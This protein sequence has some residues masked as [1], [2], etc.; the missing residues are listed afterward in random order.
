MYG[1][2]LKN[3]IFRLFLFNYRISNINIYDKNTIKK[4]Y[5][6]FSKN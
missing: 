4:I 6:R 1:Y 2:C 3:K 5:L